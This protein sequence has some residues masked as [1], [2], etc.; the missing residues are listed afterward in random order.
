MIEQQLR[1]LKAT[2]AS[3]MAQVEA[4][5]ATLPAAPEGCQHE[6]LADIRTM[7]NPKRWLCRSCGAHVEKE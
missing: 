2:I 6:S 3:L 1:A 7:E 5:E 4:L